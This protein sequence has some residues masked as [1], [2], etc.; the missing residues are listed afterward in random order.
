MILLGVVF[1]QQKKNNIYIL[2]LSRVKTT[3][4]NRQLIKNIKNKLHI[5]FFY[6]FIFN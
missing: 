2:I 5:I 4:E 6:S 3:P 1:T